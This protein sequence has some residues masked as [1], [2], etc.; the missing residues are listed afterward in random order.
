MFL[1]LQ[2][3]RNLRDRDNY[4]NR[5]SR[6]QGSR[7][8]FARLTAFDVACP[9]C[10]TV[11]SVS[12]LRPWWKRKANFDPWRSRWRCRTCR[13]VFAVGVVLWPVSNAGGRPRESRPADTIPTTQELLGLQLVA[14]RG[15]NDPVNLTCEC[16]GTDST[17]CALHGAGSI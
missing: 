1:S 8:T 3:A 13:R 5:L 16:S 11:D 2:L 15:W 17:A 12:C 6:S 7:R 9:R 10:G 4:F 14:E